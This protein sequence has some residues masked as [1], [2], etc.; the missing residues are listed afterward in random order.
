[1]TDTV[2]SQNIDLGSWATL[3]KNTHHLRATDLTQYITVFWTRSFT[4]RLSE[5]TKLS[6]KRE[7]LSAEE[8]PTVTEL[9]TLTLGDG[10]CRADETANSPDCKQV[11]RSISVRNA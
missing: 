8:E 3:Y 7:L 4:A 1:M 10:S 6:E 9:R 11:C 2:T 5:P